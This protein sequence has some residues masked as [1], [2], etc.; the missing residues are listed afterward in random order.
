MT[1]YRYTNIVTLLHCYIVYIV[2]LL[3]CYIVYI[4]QY[5]IYILMYSHESQLCFTFLQQNGTSN[6][7]VNILYV[8][9]LLKYRRDRIMLL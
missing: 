3:H 7:Q 6:G 5:P 4:S 8:L 9:L 1:K 2:T